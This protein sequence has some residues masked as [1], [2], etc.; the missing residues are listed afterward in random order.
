MRLCLPLVLIAS[1]FAVQAVAQPAM[2]SR[3]AGLWQ[4]TIT[5]GKAGKPQP[6]MVTTICLDASVDKAM[7]VFSQGAGQQSCTSNS[8]TRAGAGYRFASTCKFAG[9]GVINTQGTVSG[10]FGSA[11]SVQMNSVVT[12]AAMA[13]MNGASAT[14]IA[15]KWL[16]ACPAGSKPGD[17]T[18][19]GGIKVNMM[20]AMA[21]APR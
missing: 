21:R 13:A 5:T 12:G 9:A 16:G 15:A 10:D 11:Y 20:S 8:V 3:K 2:P 18:M 7:S 14:T 4:Q 19:P 17:M 6:P 1:A